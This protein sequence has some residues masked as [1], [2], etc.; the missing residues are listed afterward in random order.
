MGADQE[1]LVRAITTV[2]NGRA[3]FGVLALRIAEFFHRR[4]LRPGDR[5]PSADRPRARGARP[6][7][8]RALQRAHRRDALPVAEDRAEQGVNVLT[9]LQVTDRAQAIVRAREA[10]L[11]R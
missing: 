5:L 7:R 2:A 3:V 4:S 11:G 1:G 10:G 9:K 6:G 8:G